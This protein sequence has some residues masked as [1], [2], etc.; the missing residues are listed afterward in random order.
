MPIRFRLYEDLY[1]FLLYEIY[2]LALTQQI[3]LG[4]WASIV[5]YSASLFLPIVPATNKAW[6]VMAS[7]VYINDW[8]G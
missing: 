1:G 7:R 8:C 2:E 5:L 4:F 6:K 3:A